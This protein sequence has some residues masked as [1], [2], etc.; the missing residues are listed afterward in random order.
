[1]TIEVPSPCISVCIMHSASQLCTG[2]YRTIEEIGAWSRLDNAGKEAIWL[3][4]E[5]RQLDA[6]QLQTP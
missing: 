5:Q 1:M 3:R 6:L 2:C 4:I